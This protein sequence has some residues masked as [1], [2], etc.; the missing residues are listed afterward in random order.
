MTVSPSVLVTG[1][2]GFI[3]AVLIPRLLESGVNVEGADVGWFSGSSSSNDFL[4]L[5]AEKLKNFDAIIHLAGLSDDK[6]CNAYPEKADEINIHQTVALAERCKRAGIKRFVL[7]SSSAVYGN[8]DAV[9]TESAAPNPDTVYSRGKLKAEEQLIALSSSDF[10][11]VCLRFG[12]GYGVSPKPR[13]DLVL[14]RLARIALSKGV[15]GL[16][17]DGTCYRPFLHVND[18]AQALVHAAINPDVARQHNIFNIS[19][20]DGNIT[21]GAAVEQ[22]AQVCD[23]KLNDPLPAVD[24]RSYRIDP[25]RFIDTGFR[26]QWP[27]QDGLELLVRQLRFEQSAEPEQDRVAKLGTVFSLAGASA[28]GATGS[29][30]SVSPS[31]LPDVSHD[32]YVANVS[33]IISKS[34]Y[35]MAGAHCTKAEELLAAEYHTNDNHGVLM[36]RSGT[37]ALMRALQVT[38]VKAGDQVG[39]PDQCFHAVAVSVMTLGAIPVLIDTRADDFNLDASALEATLASKSLKAVIAVDNY[40]TPA[41]WKSIAAVTK[42]HNIP[43]I[44]DACESLG[45]SRLHQHVIDYA[46]IVVVSFSFTKPIHAAG[47]GGALIADKSITREIESNEAY[48]YRQL[49]LPE[50]NAA[51]LVHAWDRLHTNIDHLRDIYAQYR[52]TAMALGFES[53][54][55]CGRSTRI[56]APFLIPAEWPADARDALL[57]ALNKNGVSAGNQF[58]AQSQLLSLDSDCTISKDTAA[59]VITLPT[60][61]GLKTRDVETVRQRFSRTVEAYSVGLDSSSN[62]AEKVS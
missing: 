30:G 19:H 57:Q 6:L 49:R 8:T 1:S 3:G 21:V 2:G 37:D 12:S 55:E 11:V 32:A 7:A 44:V 36:M 29:I 22:L 60:G 61:G 48:L 14:N 9:V 16:T 4:S 52:E 45:A 50:I 46:S 27:L 15:I 23:A 18:M 13:N 38:G 62:N 54:A 28:A 10:E 39:I 35:R 59:R 26:Y 5:D 47:M 41:D 33:S 34:S 53:Q 56:H 20:P 58:A 31:A 40:G 25:T 42:A 24:P 17:T 51:Y 43:F